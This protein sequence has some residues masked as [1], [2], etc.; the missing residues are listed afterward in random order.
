MLRRLP[1]VRTD[2]SEERSATNIRV[3]RIGE[4]GTTLAV[5]SSVRQ[6]LVTANVPSSPILVILMMEALSFAETSVLIKAIRRNIPDHGIPHSHRR[7]NLKYCI[8]ILFIVGSVPI[9]L[10]SA[11][12]L[13][14][15]WVK[16]GG[17]SSRQEQFLAIAEDKIEVACVGTSESS[18]TKLL[19][20]TPLSWT[21]SMK[22]LVPHPLF[23]DRLWRSRHGCMATESGTEKV[24]HSNSRR[25]SDAEIIV[26]GMLGTGKVPLL[27][28]MFV[29]P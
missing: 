12:C 2:V 17:G 21:R 7:E 4:L 5:T 9:R 29:H 23:T 6:L 28:P 19:C 24:P 20:F 27:N 25:Q 8:S 11:A 16:G 26:I 18:Y 1:L 3:T 15:G 10:R 13:R 14:L 22:A